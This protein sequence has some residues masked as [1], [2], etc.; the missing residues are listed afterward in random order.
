MK[1]L[2]LDVAASTGVAYWDTRNSRSS[3]ITATLRTPG[4]KVTAEQR[5]YNFEDQLTE[6]FRSPPMI[7]N[8]DFVIIEQRPLNVYKGTHVNAALNTN[9]YVGAFIGIMA[10]MALPYQMVPVQTWRAAQYGAAQKGLDAKGKKALAKDLAEIEG[11][12]CKNND[13]AEAA[14]LVQWGAKSSI[15]AKQVKMGEKS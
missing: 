7:I 2:G 4:T 1:I 8:P 15:F 12:Q 9:L 10:A 3:I 11:I 6:F 5:A 14:Q 13:E